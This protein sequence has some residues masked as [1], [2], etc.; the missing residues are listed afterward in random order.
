MIST[1]CCS[2]QLM[3]NSCP[4]CRRLTYITKCSSGVDTSSAHTKATGLNYSKPRLIPHC[5][6]NPLGQTNLV[7]VEVL[8]LLQCSGLLAILSAWTW[9]IL[10]RTTPKHKP[11]AINSDYN[12][13]KIYIFFHRF[14]LSL[15]CKN[16]LTTLV[17]LPFLFQNTICFLIL[18]WS[19]LQR[20]SKI[21]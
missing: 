20:D 6:T 7:I 4:A 19:L 16:L 21:T 15:L 2:S 5:L 12:F 10:S 17:N 1:S 8:S 3:I 9:K 14:L 13:L 18:S 11:N